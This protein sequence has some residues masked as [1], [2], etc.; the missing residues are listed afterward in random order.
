MVLIEKCITKISK[1]IESIGPIEEKK[2]RMLTRVIFGR[3]ALAE[4]NYLVDISWGKIILLVLGEHFKNSSDY[5]SLISDLKSVG[6]EVIIYNNKI[7]KSDFKSIDRLANFCRNNIPDIIVAIGGG[8]ILDTGKSAAILARNEGAVNDYFNGNIRKLEYPGIYFI[9]VPTTA[10][11]G[12]EVTPWATVWDTENKNKYSLSSLLMFPKLAIVDPALTDSLP[13]KVTSETGIDALAQAIEAYWS[14]NHNI[15]SDQFALK[16]IKLSMDNIGRLTGND[17]KK[18]RNNM[19]KASLLS[20]LAFSNT[21]TTICHSI[22]YPL[23]IY[24]NISHGQAVALTLPLFIE[25]I[26][27]AIEKERRDILLQNLLAKDESE[28]REVVASL[29]KK[30]G[31]STRFSDLGISKKDIKMIVDKGLNPEIARNSPR[32]P[33]PI[34]LERM[35]NSIY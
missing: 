3:G 23:T 9:A 5:F 18:L 19:A 6:K 8:T 14:V 2:Y 28:A 13:A 7:T 4:K 34:E 33:N 30:A 26:I 24:F 16:S 20:G 11:T 31:L 27:P 29:I 15:V 22:S 32:I 35:L 12:S 17:N 25:Y 1:W 21:Q 10:G